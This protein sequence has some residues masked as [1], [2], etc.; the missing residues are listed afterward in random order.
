MPR[1]PTLNSLSR[2]IFLAFDRILGY[3]VLAVYG[4][5]NCR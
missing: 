3:N 1:Q 5:F 2:K 4:K